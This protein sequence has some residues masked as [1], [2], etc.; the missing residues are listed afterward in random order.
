MFFSIR[1]P[2]KTRIQISD[3]ISHFKW[4]LRSLRLFPLIQMWWITFSSLML[5]QLENCVTDR[6]LRLISAAYGGVCSP[7]GVLTLLGYWDWGL[8]ER[9]HRGTS[10]HKRAESTTGVWDQM[11]SHQK[12]KMRALRNCQN[13]FHN[14]KCYWRPLGSIIYFVPA[15]SLLSSQLGDIDRCRYLK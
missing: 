4:F 6:W 9:G 1:S 14:V 11:E 2:N 12:V 10:V 8:K 15:L 13:Y 3:D 7:N 5:F